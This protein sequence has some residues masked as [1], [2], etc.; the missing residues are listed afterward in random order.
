VAVN[1]GVVIAAPRPAEAALHNEH[2]QR[3]PSG[4]HLAQF[5]STDEIPAV[6]EFAEPLLAS[7]LSRCPIAALLTTHQDRFTRRSKRK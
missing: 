2:R 5:R 1:L 3:L 6:G 4:G 7:S